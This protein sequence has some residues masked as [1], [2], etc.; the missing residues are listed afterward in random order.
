MFSVAAG[1]G[2]YSLICAT[3]GSQPRANVDLRISA[4]LQLTSN[5]STSTTATQLLVLTSNPEGV[6]TPGAA[7]FSPSSTTSLT[8][9][10]TSVLRPAVTIS[11]SPSNWRSAK[12]IGFVPLVQPGTAISLQ[13]TPYSADPM[14]S[15]LKVG[16]L[17]AAT[18]PVLRYSFPS[19]RVLAVAEGGP[20]VLFNVSALPGVNTSGLGN[21]TVVASSGY[22]VVAG[23]TRFSLPCTMD[24][25]CIRPDIDP[26]GAM[27]SFV[28]RQGLGITVSP[29][30]IDLSD[31]TSPKSVNVGAM[32]DAVFEGS[33]H[34]AQI[35]FFSASTG[36]YIGGTSVL[37][38]DNDGSGLNVTVIRPIA[39]EDGSAR[40]LYALSLRAA[41]SAPVTVTPAITPLLLISNVTSLTFFDA[42]NWAVPQFVELTAVQDAISSGS[43]PANTVAI[44]LRHLMTSDDSAY[45]GTDLSSVTS[46]TVVDDDV[47][48]IALMSCSGGVCSRLSANGVSITEGTN[49]TVF[50]TLTSQPSAGGLSVRL[51]SDLPIFA[52]P[53]AG[54]STMTDVRFGVDQTF[55][56]LIPVN[57]GALDD[58]A[59]G[60][61]L[62]APSV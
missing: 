59:S 56:A 40:A 39:A 26:T 49:S 9:A 1:S 61:S 17:F 38:A 58:S 60:A 50:L 34:A 47:A 4:S 55:N 20:S 46:L 52:S 16:C 15:A 31:P 43:G 8:D 6:T 23:I 5:T 25:D 3:L 36:A 42:T 28:C 29:S 21:V 14:Y 13:V 57:L 35:K 51:S 2:G 22:C 62:R 33:P 24:G 41:P 11:F 48:S 27:D 37:I 18:A 10:L 32:D 12:C 44:T 53:A 54:L 7:V 30:S 19:N 45:T